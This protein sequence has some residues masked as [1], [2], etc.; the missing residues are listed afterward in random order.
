MRIVRR[1][2]ATLERTDV[3]TNWLAEIFS[4][5][6]FKSTPIVEIET[7]VLLEKTL[8][9]F[10]ANVSPLAR[11]PFLRSATQY[12]GRE[13]QNYND[14]YIYKRVISTRVIRFVDKNGQVSILNIY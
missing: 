10:P 5:T 11:V 2:S 7:A 8:F 13:Y 3:V 12:T 9:R 1:M 6:P 4:E 14:I